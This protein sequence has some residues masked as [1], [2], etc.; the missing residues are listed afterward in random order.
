[1][2]LPENFSPWEHLQSTLI[3]VHNGLVRE[4]FLG[5]DD[6]DLSTPRSSLK[7]ACTMKDDDSAL[8]T[9]IRL[10]LFYVIVRKASE[11]Q[12]A[13]Y[14][15]PVSTFQENV[16]YHPQVT[17]FFTEDLHQVE[18]GY[19]PIRRR[20]SF[21]LMRETATTIT[22][23]EAESLAREILTVFRHYVWHTG[24]TMVT[25]RDDQKGFL[26]RLRCFNKNEGMQLIRAVARVAN[27]SVDEDKISVSELL[28]PPPIVPPTKEIMGKPIRQPR[29][30]PVAFCKFRYA[31]L[32]IH[33]MPNPVILVDTTGF[34]RQALVRSY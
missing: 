17:L 34:K 22:K 7:L 25:Y 21:R 15:I 23:K 9:L 20:V 10:W 6:D 31:E 12:P 1:M 26:F 18:T 8:M 32:D 3:N 5:E 28:N 19:E 33:G 30:N 16:K 2:P 4:E 11:F 13:I 27:Q 24:R 14:G 29:V